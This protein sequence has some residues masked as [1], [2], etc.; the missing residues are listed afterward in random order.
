MQ[1]PADDSVLVEPAPTEPVPIKPVKH[2]YKVSHSSV[3]HQGRGIHLILLFFFF[4]MFAGTA[5]LSYQA[6]NTSVVELKLLGETT[7]DLTDSGEFTEPG[8]TASHCYLAR[9]QDLTDKV[10]VSNPNAEDIKNRVIGTYK[11]SYDLKYGADTYSKS[12]E[13]LIADT[14]PPTIALEGPE[15]VGLYVGQSYTEPGFTASDTHDGDVTTSVTVDNPVNLSRLGV[16]NITYTATDQAGN[17][18]TATRR[19]FVYNYSALSSEPIA[20]FDE[21]LA[22]VKSFNRDISFGY[23]NFNNNTEYTY[24]PDR[25]YYGA[26]LVKTLDALYVYETFGGPRDWNERYLLQS[27]ISMSNN[28]AHAAVASNLGLGNLRN[29]GESIG[30]KHHLKGSIFYSDVNLFCDTTVSDQLTEWTH[31]WELINQLPNGSELAN[32]FI[33]GAYATMDFYGAP[34]MAFKAGFYGGTH[35]E[36]ALFYA[37]SP[38]VFTILS[39]NGYDPYREVI[40]RDLSERI[41]LINQTL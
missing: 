33:N 11:I 15:N 7:L 8:F 16:Y 2:R 21:L 41:Y 35:H 14:T 27:A 3:R 32:L 36:T 24:Q 30:M 13:I 18:A 25:V 39:M 5:Y 31:L 26:S 12:R 38:Y 1:N 20:T 19:V 6:Y 37:D 28:S 29:Y 22:Y 9:C 40:M 23:K 17:T 10:V 34:T 4:L